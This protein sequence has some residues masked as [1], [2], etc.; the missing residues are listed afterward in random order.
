MLGNKHPVMEQNI[1]EELRPSKSRSVDARPTCS[2][3]SLN[4]S[5]KNNFNYMMMGESLW[6]NP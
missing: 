3:L 6:Q 4:F 1:P 5:A 2:L